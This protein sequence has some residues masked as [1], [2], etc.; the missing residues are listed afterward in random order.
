MS[1]PTILSSSLNILS[2]LICPEGTAVIIYDPGKLLV[3]DEFTDFTLEFS[4]SDLAHRLEPAARATTCV[5]NLSEDELTVPVPGWLIEFNGG[6]SYPGMDNQ[7]WNIINNPDGSPRWL[8]PSVLRKPRF[9][10][11]YNFN[12]W[13]ARLYKC[14]INAAY[15]LRMPALVR[16]GYMV[17]HHRQALHVE[18]L[19]GRSCGRDRDYAVFTGTAGPNRK[20]V[21]AEASGGLVRSFLKIALNERSAENI[22]N[23]YKSLCLMS[24][25]PFCGA[26]IPGVWKIDE[27]TIRVTNVKPAAERKQRGFG[28]S[29]CRFL[30]CLFDSTAGQQPYREMEV[31]RE[32]AERLNCLTAQP[33]LR[34]TDGALEL[35]YK[36]KEL[37]SQLQD[38][39]PM[40][41]TSVAH[42]DFTPWNVYSR[43]K[44]LFVYDWEFC[45]RGMPALF[46]LFHYVIQG[47]VFAENA[48]ATELKVQLDGMLSGP[49]PEF[50][51]KARGLDPILCLQL[52]L[53]YNAAYYLEVYLMQDKLHR[54]AYRLFAVW[55]ELIDVASPFPRRSDSPAGLSQRAVFILSFWGSLREK[56]YVVL[57]TAGK[58]VQN[59]SLESDLDILI[60]KT[61]LKRALDWIKDYPG[62]KKLR[63][64]RKSFMTT[65][66]LFF[67]DNSFLSI[68][69]LTAF[70]RKSL[71]Y[72]DAR[73]M[74]DHAV[75]EDGINILPPA[76]DYLYIYLFYQ[77]NFDAVPAKYSNCFNPTREEI[78]T[79]T[80]KLLS[81]RTGIRARRLADTFACSAA[82]RRKSIGFL[83]Q[84]PANGLSLRLV[85]WLRYAMDSL[86]D[87][88]RAK[89]IML[90]FSGVDG[91]G[92]TTILGEVRDLLE[93]KYRRKVV[94]LRH[95]PSVLPILSA[96]KYGKEEAEKKCVESLPRKGT[97]RS[98]F[99]SLFR[100]AYYYTDFLLGQLLIY[101]KYMLRG[102]VVLYDRY[103]FDFIVDGKR[104]NILLP[105]VFIR[106]LYRF[107]YKPQ[108]NV[109]LYAAPDVIL[110]RKKELS[111]TDITQLTDRYKT[112]F[113]RLGSEQK[114]LCIENMDRKV[115]MARIEQAFIQLN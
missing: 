53:L 68:D 102:Y 113:H 84:K 110:R 72:I 15:F 9:L 66:Q 65:I 95:R 47:K 13:K 50:F 61:D 107:V 51:L 92:K 105:S 91:A 82:G 33:R 8:Y 7:T 52:Y 54:E 23:E 22:R 10:A 12:Y 111:A 115:T 86:R 67:N 98:F 58:S 103:Y 40:V 46:D 28:P 41:W 44:T 17:I 77:L 89:G 62:V 43:G 42:G 27:H 87:L 55:S 97:N 59:L 6:Y 75:E 63:Y 26:V 49:V 4:H 14:L 2:Q 104:S 83:L 96:W 31:F 20:A 81:R 106:Q 29:H 21:V 11:F 94:V 70:H 74:L 93:K 85:R 78:E 48:S 30:Q 16:S 108:L 56:K 35:F 1:K 45:R 80:L 101:G 32:T 71:E 36:L 100:F 79:T 57:K 34:E 60:Q 90:T 112:L 38:R 76:Y 39:N 37:E 88:L 3:H 109:F 5:F 19:I 99:S 114:Y 25:V 18:T 24:H 69:L 64:T 73:E